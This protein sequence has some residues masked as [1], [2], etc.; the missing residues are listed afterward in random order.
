MK[1][2]LSILLL[3]DLLLTVAVACGKQTSSDEA[4]ASPTSTATDTQSPSAATSEASDPSSRSRLDVGGSGDPI[5][6]SWE[7]A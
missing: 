4:S 3:A 1:K 6:F 7:D 5:E 2:I